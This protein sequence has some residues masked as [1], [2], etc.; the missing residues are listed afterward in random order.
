LIVR[1]GSQIRHK[2]EHA[3]ILSPQHFVTRPAS[4]FGGVERAICCA[5]VTSSDSSCNMSFL[6]LTMIRRYV[7]HTAEHPRQYTDGE[8]RCS[9]D[10][11]E[12]T[13][14]K[15]GRD[16]I[17]LFSERSGEGAESGECFGFE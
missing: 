2:A 7:L 3:T 15:E 11:V 5:T 8:Q 12:T 17:F 16:A 9:H 14:K 6:K 1:R 13:S 4:S 10:S